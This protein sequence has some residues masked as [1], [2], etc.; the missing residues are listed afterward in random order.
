M[1][2][3][4]AIFSLVMGFIGC[5]EAEHSLCCDTIYDTEVIINSDSYTNAIKNEVTIHSLEIL[6]NEGLK[7]NFSASGCSGDTW[8]VS[9]IDSEAILESSPL[10][11]NLIFSLNNEEECEAF[12]MKDIYV[13]IKNLKI[14]G[15]N[16]IQ[17]NITNT[18]DKILYEY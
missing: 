2:F 13:S 14:E 8:E 17:L 9:L 16:K 4:I 10:Q 18:G 1:K 6:D 5:K 7:I 12:I 15:E 3:K 11:R